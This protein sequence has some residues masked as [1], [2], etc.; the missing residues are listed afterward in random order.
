MSEML[1][2]HSM[3]I[4]EDMAVFMFQCSRGPQLPFIWPNEKVRDQV[5]PSFELWSLD[6][7]SKV[8]NITPWNTT[9]INITFIKKITSSICT[10][11]QVWTKFDEL[12][13]KVDLPS[14]IWTPGKE[15]TKFN[16]L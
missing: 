14:Y 1:L 15:E 10:L 2:F 11:P 7:K 12:T 4:S 3:F 9:Y 5:P 16:M 6:S 8:L 13:N